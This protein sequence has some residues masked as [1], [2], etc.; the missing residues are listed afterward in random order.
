MMEKVAVGDLK[1]KS[2]RRWREVIA[3]VLCY[4]FGPLGGLWVLSSPASRFGWLARFHAVHS[5]LMSGVFIGGWSLLRG[6]E[7][8]FP[9]FLSTVMREIRVIAAYG[10][11]PVWVAAMV[12]VWRNQRFSPVPVLHALAVKGARHLERLEARRRTTEPRAA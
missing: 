6:I 8:L 4:A 3:S 12:C 1:V 7:E 10:S 2:Q 11:I 5:L 9:W